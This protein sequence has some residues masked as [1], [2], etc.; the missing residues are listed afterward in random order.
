ME[1]ASNPGVGVEAC[2]AVAFVS[3]LD[4]IGLVGVVGAGGWREG[5]DGATTAP[6]FTARW[7]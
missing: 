7:A 2:L 5:L 6:R 4:L 1:V 3:L